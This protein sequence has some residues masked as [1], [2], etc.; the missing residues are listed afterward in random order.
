MWKVFLLLEAILL[1]AQHP[2]ITTPSMTRPRWL[3]FRNTNWVAYVRFKVRPDLDCD[4][5]RFLLSTRD[6][7]ILNH[8]RIDSIL[9]ELSPTA[10]EAA[11]ECTEK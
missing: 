2:Q 3:I 7:G 4:K 11:C 10:Q 1:A 9:M 8:I 6:V 5:I